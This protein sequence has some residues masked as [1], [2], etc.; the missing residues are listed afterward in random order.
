MTDQID[1]KRSAAVPKLDEETFDAF[2]L[3]RRPF[4]PISTMNGLD[5]YLTALII[6]PKFID[7]FQRI[8]LFAGEDALNAPMKTAEHQAVQTIVAEYNRISST[9]A[10]EPKSLRPTF[11][12]M[13]DKTFDSSDWS[14]GFL[15]GTD[16][17][18]KH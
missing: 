17:A 16:Y 14:S 18:A 3:K 6:G 4:P 11:K 13:G 7:R 12:D 10:E 1:K 15:M 2:P 9:L 5:G 8:P